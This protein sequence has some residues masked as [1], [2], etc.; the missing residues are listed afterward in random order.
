MV[1][2]ARMDTQLHTHLRAHRKARGLS[3]EHVANILGVRQNTL[4]Q[5]ETGKRGVD[6]SDLEKL[7]GVYG[8]SPSAL[9]MAP[10]DNPKAEQM[11]VAAD[12]ASRMDQDTLADWLRMGAKLAPPKAG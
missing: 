8:V 5:W 9:L 2:Y 6:L 7:A 3:L 1:H 4:S 12:I 11:R 10:E